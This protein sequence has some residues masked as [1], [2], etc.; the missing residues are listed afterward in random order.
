[1]KTPTL[2]G[3]RIFVLVQALCTLLAAAIGSEPPLAVAT[4]A[5]RLPGDQCIFYSSIAAN[6]HGEVVVAGR[7][8]N[9]RTIVWT[10]RDCGESFGEPHLAL[11]QEDTSTSHK[12]V[13]LQSDDV[14][15]FY[16]SIGAKQ[17]EK[18]PGPL[19]YLWKSVDAGATWKLLNRSADG[20]ETD[21]S[22]MAVSP[23]GTQLIHIVPGIQKLSLFVSKNRGED[24]VL[25]TFRTTGSGFP[26][27]ALVND[28]G[29]AMIV[30]RER[31]PPS[32]WRIDVAAIA[33]NGANWNRST[34]G[35]IGEIM[36]ESRKQFAVF[37]G[38]CHSGVA[39]DDNGSGTYCLLSVERDW[40]Q[41]GERGHV[42]FRTSINGN[43]WSQASE[44]S[45]T[46]TGVKAFPAITATGNRIH[47][48]WVEADREGWGNLWYRGSLDE[49][50]TWSEPILVSKT[51]QPTELLTPQG[52]RKCVS[53]FFESNMAED[54][55]GTA[56][57][58]WGAGD[59]IQ[60][61]GEPWHASVRLQS[62]L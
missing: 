50:K 34:V 26:F 39:I 58:V 61:E 16:L 51:D 2:I 8:E 54:G 9:G 30:Y 53:H 41:Q 27:D 47:A 38:I 36:P 48:L 5:R 40:T 10:S 23:N 11:P 37:D 7:A 15:G 24:W 59:F 18:Q 42:R 12:D 17:S 43:D 28:L 52:F 1:M 19:G 22:M 35:L 33:E 32:T 44:L 13:R 31:E 46:K 25:S 62:S 14:G 56:H 57:I 6:L 49:G 4:V 3:I 45:E 29:R 20:E 21:C 55:T 60:W